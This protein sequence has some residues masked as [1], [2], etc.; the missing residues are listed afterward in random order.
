LPERVL[1]FS[2]EK[3][4]YVFNGAKRWES[5]LNPFSNI[6]QII[7]QTFEFEWLGTVPG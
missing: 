3:A 5:A 7:A 1:F 4:R 2:C 6:A